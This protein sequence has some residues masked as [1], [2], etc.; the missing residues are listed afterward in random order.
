[1]L[2][3]IFLILPLLAALSGAALADAK[4]F[5][6]RVER[7]TGVTWLIRGMTSTRL[8]PATLLRDGDRVKVEKGSVLL[9]WPDGSKARLEP[10]SDVGWHGRSSGAVTAADIYGGSLWLHVIKFTRRPDQFEVRTHHSL[11]SVEGTEVLFRWEPK[12]QVSTLH[13]FEGA[14]QCHKGTVECER[15]TAGES[16]LHAQ[17]LPGEPVT[18]ERSSEPWPGP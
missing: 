3:R 15:V 9:A 18:D 11:G 8:H 4:W 17:G 7:V 5:S 1:M 13:V 14:V 6:A 12:S 10:G 2:R 16:H